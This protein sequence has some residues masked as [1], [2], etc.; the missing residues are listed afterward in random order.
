MQIIENEQIV[1]Y[2][3]DDTLVIW[4]S[5]C[6]PSEKIDIVNPYFGYN[7]ALKPHLRH[8]ELL[9]EHKARGNTVIVWSAAGYKWA[10][11]VVK[12]LKL[13]SYVDIC[14]SKPTKF[15]DDLPANEILGQ[16]IYLEDK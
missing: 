9:K 8:V 7:M 11:A 12:A 3:C 13:E 14:Q 5:Q 6:N 4:F 10:E 1:Y 16:R 2:D 15:V